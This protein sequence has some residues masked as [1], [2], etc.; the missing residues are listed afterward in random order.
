MVIRFIYLQKHHRDAR[1]C[2]SSQVWAGLCLN[3]LPTRFFSSLIFPTR[4]QRWCCQCCLHSTCI[5]SIICY[6][7]ALVLHICPVPDCQWTFLLRNQGGVCER[8]FEFRGKPTG[9]QFAPV[10][11]EIRLSNADTNP[12]MHLWIFRS[13]QCCLPAGLHTI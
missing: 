4:Q 13:L 10:Q 11:S 12:Q 9:F 8:N 1:P 3:N 5:I 7:N 2:S 6:C